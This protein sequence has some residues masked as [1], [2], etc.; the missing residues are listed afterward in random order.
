MRLLTAS[1]LILLTLLTAA[2]PFGA[3]AP[4]ARTA[5]DRSDLEA[6]MKQ[7]LT[8]RD[9]NWKKLQ[10]YTLEEDETFQVSALNGRK[11]YGFKREYSWFPRDP[12][13]ALGTGPSTSLGTSPSASLGTGDPVFIRSPISADGV[14]LSE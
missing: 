5:D 9:D 12:S 13:T 10:Q 3:Q 2:P 6:F 8:R 1:S 11:L 14:R 7:V 4:A